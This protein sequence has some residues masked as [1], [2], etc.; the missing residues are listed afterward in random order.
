MTIIWLRPTDSRRI[1]MI[2]MNLSDI[3]VISMNL[4]FN[5][6]CCFNSVVQ[7]YSKVS[8]I[9]K[10]AV[11]CNLTLVNRPRMMNS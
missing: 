4:H 3:L 10:C 9:F 6:F 7:Y 5:K 8:G 2:L 11:V 1:L